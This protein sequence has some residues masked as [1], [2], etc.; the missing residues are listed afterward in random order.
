MEEKE[1][2]EA[3]ILKRG[4][5]VLAFSLHRSP[6]GISMTVKAH[7]AIEEF[8]RKNSGA[9]IQTVKVASVGRYWEAKGKEPLTAYRLVEKLQPD[10]QDN[11]R[12]S[13]EHGLGDPLIIVPQRDDG[14]LRRDGPPTGLLT[15]KGGTVNLSFLRLVGISE[16]AGVSFGIKGVQSLEALQDTKDRIG[17]A[18]RAFYVQY[19]K[20][21]DLT[22]NISTQVMYP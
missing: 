15:L 4:E 14:E 21:V 2:Q 8:M 6:V 13:L 1:L 10:P 18:F 11:V 19:L 22:V 7:N 20:P 3:N 16:G 9:E 5:N 12:W 17:T